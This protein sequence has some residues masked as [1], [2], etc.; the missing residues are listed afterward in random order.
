MAAGEG[1]ARDDTATRWGM[2]ARLWTAQNRLEQ[3][4]P[5]SKP[6]C[7]CRTTIQ[8]QLLNLQSAQ[9]SAKQVRAAPSPVMSAVQDTTSG[10]TP[11]ASIS[12]NSATAFCHCPP[13]A[14]AEMTAAY[15]WP[16]GRGRGRVERHICSGKHGANELSWGTTGVP[17]RLQATSK[18]ALLA[19]TALPSAPGQP[20]SVH[21]SFKHRSV[22]THPWACTPPSACPPK[23]TAPPPSGRPRWRRASPRCRRARRAPCGCRVAHPASGEQQMRRAR[24]EALRMHAPVQPNQA[25]RRIAHLLCG[26]DACKHVPPMHPVTSRLAVQ[27]AQPTP[28]GSCTRHQPHQ[29]TARAA[30]TCAYACSARSVSPLRPH[31]SIR[32]VHRRQST[33]HLAASTSSQTWAERGEQQQQGVHAALKR[34]V[35]SW[36]VAVV[37]TTRS[38][39]CNAGGVRLQPPRPIERHNS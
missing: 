3:P 24:S 23:W 33:S 39:T 13:A 17:S 36:A 14:Q 21:R 12:S 2:G 6:A 35:S 16:A 32:V 31:T 15:A 34:G 20:M 1:Q 37:P 10:H 26:Q 9:S 27:Q 4:P 5:P 8:L 22:S 25:L 11:Q 19:A 7:R 29:H 18:P 30:R 38:R 28:R